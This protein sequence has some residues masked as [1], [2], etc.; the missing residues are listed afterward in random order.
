MK[1]VLAPDKFKGSLTAAEVAAHLAAGLRRGVPDLDVDILPVADGGEGTVEAALAAGFEPVAVDATGPLGEPVHARY[2]RRGATAVVEMAAVTG[3]QML[4]PD[5]TTARR[6][7]S[8]GLGEVVAHA[9][10]AGARE[11]VVGIGGSAST[12]GGAG[13]L[14]ALGARLTGPGGEL[15]DGGA[16][17][18]DVTGVDL[19]G[20]HPGLRTAALVLASDVDN[21][22]LGPHGAAAVYGPQKG[23]DPTA[24]AELDAALAAWVRALTR[25]GAH[26][27]QDL[28][29]AP[30]AGAAGG[31][32][33]AL[34][35]LGARRRA[36]IEVVLDLAGFAGRVHG[37]DLVVTGEGRLDE[38]SLHGKAPVGVAAAAGDVPVVAV[39]GSSAL[40]PA[41][42]RAAGIAAVHALTDLEPDVATCIAQAGPL[43]ERLGERIAAEHLGAG[44]TDASTPPAT[45]PL[46]LVVRGRRV[47]TP[48][49]WRAAEV[50]VRDG[51]I[52]EVAD[53]GAGLDAT[54]TLELAEDEVLI[55]GLVDTHVHVNQPGRTEWEGFASATRAAAAGGVT[56]IVDMPLNSVPPTTDVAA[57]DVKR[58][59]AEGGVHVD[60]AFWGG[61]VPGS[62]ADLAPLHDAGVMGFKCFLVDS[63]VEEFGHLD[64]AELERDLAELARL[65]AL[66]VVHAEDPGV[67]GAA[68]EPHGPRYADFLAS[69]PPA[70]E[71]AAIATL[72]GAAARTGARVHV[73]HLSDAAALPLITRAR[74]EGVRVSVETCPHYLTLEAEDVPDGATA[75]KCCPPIRGAANQDALWQG[76]LD[77]AIDIV[78]TDHSPSTPDLKALDTGDFGEAWGGVASLQLGLAAVWTE[79]RS[80][81]VALEQVVRWMSTSPAALVGLD[82]KGAIAPGK[83]ADLA[84]LAPEDSFD[85]DP[86]RLHHRNPVTPY[87]GRRLTGVVRRTLLHGRTITDVPTGTLLRRGDA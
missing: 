28:A 36:G 18:A 80:R 2:A 69:R 54:E 76:L 22:L 82:R 83:D 63:G 44:P 1:V 32:G 5:P 30:S 23:A 3:L 43:L 21:P 58:A 27:A 34:L 72:L 61:A 45:A 71:E 59:E 62:A 75:F 86:A 55:P 25:A 26:D 11:V 9:L 6:A 50:G 15:P 37:A 87:A 48:Q 81:G 84:V 24:V 56:T 46:D 39:C 51:V 12:D 53:L 78:V 13:M 20:L 85:V 38:Q 52:V 40:D 19:S 7:S 67:I 60:V 64:A 42:A 4:D 73:L 68:P 16:A 17:L 65:D 41:R 29:A 66:M 35:L 77:G 74:A 33:Y 57:L 10:D 31:V 49:G 79:A 47:L 70:A 8:R 14:A